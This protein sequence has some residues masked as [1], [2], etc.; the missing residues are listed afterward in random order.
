M[1][2][3]VAH[4]PE[5]KQDLTFFENVISGQY[6]RCSHCG[7]DLEIIDADTMEMDWAYRPFADRDS[8]HEP[9]AF[10]DIGWN[11]S[12]LGRDEAPDETDDNMD[13]WEMSAG[14]GEI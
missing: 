13:D 8:W 11:K 12:R 4:C 3:E 7:A 5:C 9:D 10:L 6:V 14:I 2:A 1:M